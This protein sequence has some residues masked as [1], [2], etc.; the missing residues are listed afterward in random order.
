M[1]DFKKYF[2]THLKANLRPLIYIFTLVL[3]LTL[4]LSNN[5]QPSERYDV[6]A[7]Q[8]IS[9]YS[10]T[11]GVPV[12]FLCVLAYVLPVM[13]FS[14]FKKRNNLDCVYSLPISRKTMGAVHYFMGLIILLCA[15]T[16][17]YI[18]NFILL[19]TRGPGWFHFTPMLAHY[20]LCLLLGAA[21]YALMVFVFNAANTQGDG[22]WFM[23]LYTFVFFLIGLLI[24]GILDT[25]VGFA[26]PAVPWGAISIVTTLYEG[27]VE[28]GAGKGYSFYEGLPVI[29]TVILWSLIGIASAVGFF[30]TFGK[31]RMEKTEEISDSFLGYRTLIPIF[32]IGGMLLFQMLD[33]II[34]RVIIQ[35][36]A[37]LGY[38]IYR[39]GFHYKKSD[40]LFLCISLI[41]LF[42]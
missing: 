10:A 35:M 28:L 38:T 24:T 4:L 25:D 29:L 13:E 27:L 14:F 12:L 5:L 7:H 33:S 3:V 23:V 2:H 6:A 37:I 39:R 20:F 15:F 1:K 18:L 21:M 11:L 40:I 36:L 32:A 16:A 17:S 34:I 31:R 26:F 22:I 9:Y 42:V 30:C 8:F 19:L 41:F